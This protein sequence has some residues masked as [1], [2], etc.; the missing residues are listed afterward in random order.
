MKII[1]AVAAVEIEE[2]KYLKGNSGSSSINSKRCKTDNS[3]DKCKGKMT[4][5][6]LLNF[7]VLSDMDN[8]NIKMYSIL[9]L[10][11]IL[12]LKQAPICDMHLVSYTQSC[13]RLLHLFLYKV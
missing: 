1:I 8:D 10:T 2:D 6:L 4:M 5:V 7:I 3:N 12:W 13:G 11:L 9:V